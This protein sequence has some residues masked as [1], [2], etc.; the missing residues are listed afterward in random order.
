MR[1]DNASISY[2]EKG[3][4]FFWNEIQ[5]MEKPGDDEGKK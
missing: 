1:L 2:D 4:S 3:N 5:N